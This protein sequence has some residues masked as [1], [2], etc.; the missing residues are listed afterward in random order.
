MRA[1]QAGLTQT[2][3]KTQVRPFEMPVMV[4]CEVGWFREC[5]R[6][7]SWNA[8]FS[9]FDRETVEIHSV[10]DGC[11]P[12]LLRDLRRDIAAK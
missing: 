10:C 8:A 5:E 11:L 1:N 3:G 9:I 12:R 4:G 2:K 6:C 7:H